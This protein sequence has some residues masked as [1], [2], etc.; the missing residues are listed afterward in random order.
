MNTVKSFLIKQYKL[1][2]HAFTIH[3]RGH[4]MFHDIDDLIS[5]KDNFIDYIKFDY[6]LTMFYLIKII[7][8][9]SKGIIIYQTIRIFFNCSSDN[10]KC[11]RKLMY[12]TRSNIFYYNSRLGN[13]M[14]LLYTAFFI[15]LR[16]ANTCDNATQFYYI[17]DWLIFDFFLRLVISFVN[18]YLNFTFQVNEADVTSNG[19]FEYEN[20]VSSHILE[21]I[22]SE[23]LTEENYSSL[24]I[25]ST[26]D[27]N[28]TNDS[29]NECTICLYDLKISQVLKYFHVIKAYFS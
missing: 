29:L 15:C 12:M 14:L 25:K 13:M 28:N 5:L 18:Y 26:N 8:L 2:N 23:Q 22:Y 3:P 7:E 10:I 24:I 17:I 27:K 4:A 16:R 19:V 9:V 21:F 6:T 1:Q 20:G 11:T